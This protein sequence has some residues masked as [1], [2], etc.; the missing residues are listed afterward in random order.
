MPSSSG[1]HDHLHGI[2][3]IAV[4]GAVLGDDA[5]FELL[6][7]ILIRQGHFGIDRATDDEPRASGEFASLQF[8]ARHR[9]AVRRVLPMEEDPGV[10]WR[11]ASAGR[12]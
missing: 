4:G 7:A 10:P 9:A 12:A 3:R 8:L 1:L 11:T 5:I 2:A 6:G